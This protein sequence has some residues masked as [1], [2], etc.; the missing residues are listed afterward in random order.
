MTAM[1]GS[2]LSSTGPRLEAITVGLGEFRVTAD[3]QALLACLGLG[4]C[5]GLA[6][7]EPMTRVAALAH[8]VLPSGGEGRP[9]GGGARFIDS[10]VPRVVAEMER[11][12]A[13]R[14]FIFARLAGGAQ[15][16]P[17]AR[18]VRVG[19]RNVEAAIEALRALSIPIG[20][21]HVGGECGRTIRL[22][23]AT[24]RL[25]VSVVGGATFEI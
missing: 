21:T 23:C 17:A 14:R 7:Y 16:V 22:H 10:G 12:G 15:V 1:A 11:L 18:A 19:E 24:G 13:T 8:F 3:P 5:L 20:A 4:S 9:D 6:L 2:P 25:V